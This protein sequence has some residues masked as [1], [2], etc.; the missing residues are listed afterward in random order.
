LD[1]INT[2][3]VKIDPNNIDYEVLSEAAF[4]IKNG[5][6]VIFPTET[7]YGLGANALNDDACDKIYKAKGRPNDNPLIVH[8]NSMDELSKLVKIIPENAKILA[9]KFWPGPL[10]MIFDKQDIISYKITAGLETVAIRM[11]QN[12][13][14]TELIRLS[15]CPIAAPSANT[16]GKPSPTLAQHVIEDMLG[17]VDMIIDGGACDIGLESSVIDMTSETPTILRPGKVTKEDIE[18]LFGKCDTDPA[19]IKSDEKLVPKSPGQ[20]YRHY[21]PKVELVLYKG[22][23]SKMVSSIKKDCSDYLRQAKKVGIIASEQTKKLYDNFNN[24]IV[25]KVVGDRKNPLTI[26]SNLFNVLRS[27]DSTKVDIILSESFNDEGIGGAIM[28]RLGKAA[29]KT[30]E[31]GELKILF[32]CTGNTC[33][34][35]MAE[36]IIKDIAQK[37]G[38]EIEASSAGISAMGDDNASINAV[39]ALNKMQIDINSHKSRLINEKMLEDADLII[40]MTNQH[41]DFLLRRYDNL[42]N[43]IISYNI[44]DPYGGNYDIYQLCSEEIK[45]EILNTVDK[46]ML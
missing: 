13:I 39:Q 43:K 4:I 7:V 23:L 14:A 26:A 2:K 25:I 19:I 8:I 34:S 21:S 41:K 30:I 5:G 18:K 46:L 3:L 40:T 10:T 27:F 24:D 37:I 38:W 22:N 44:H 20:K 28:N 16:S 1:I 11:P 6:T 12:K 15:G 33:R 36:G 35:P 42:E 17:R 45:R 9:D 32:V 31:L 29:S